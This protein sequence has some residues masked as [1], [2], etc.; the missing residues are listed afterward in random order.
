MTMTTMTM[1]DPNNI[2]EG[3]S[4]PVVGTGAE[5]DATKDDASSSGSQS[6]SGDESDDDEDDNRKDN[7]GNVD[8]EHHGVMPTSEDD[9][10]ES[11]DENISSN[12]INIP[13]EVISSPQDNATTG[14]SEPSTTVIRSARRATTGVGHKQEHAHIKGEDPDTDN[15]LND[16][17]RSAGSEPTPERTNTEDIQDQICQDRDNKYGVHAREGLRD[18]KTNSST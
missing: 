18:R 7:N 6:K 2:L 9:S 4:Q 16:D 8:E 15:E 14:V 5:D 13:D 10:T 11:P 12:T 3:C 1:I 17:D